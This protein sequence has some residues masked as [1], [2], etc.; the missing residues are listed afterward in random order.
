MKKLI[1]MFIICISVFG[2]KELID[3]KTNYDSIM[4][5][6]ILGSSQKELLVITGLL[7]NKEVVREIYQNGNLVLAERYKYSDNGKKY[8]FY[9]RKVQKDIDDEI[10]YYENG[11][12][13]QEFVFYPN[14][15][16]DGKNYDL[17]IIFFYAY[18]TLDGEKIDSASGKYPAMSNVLFPPVFDELPKSKEVRYL[19]KLKE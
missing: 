6:K 3:M 19:M 1:M 17:D 15:I 7:K 10:V 4:L 18:Y 9:Q 11:N 2:K 8:L 16:P 14:G 13:R 12:K 5:N